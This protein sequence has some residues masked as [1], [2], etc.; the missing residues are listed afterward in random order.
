MCQQAGSPAVPTTQNLTIQEPFRSV[1]ESM[2]ATEPQRGAD[3]MLHELDDTTRISP[4]EG[5]ALYSLVV[6]TRARATLE[7]GLA[8]GF[9]TAYLLAG[10]DRNGGGTHTAIDPYQDTDWHGVGLTTATSLV[11]QSG[12]PG[13]A[14]RFLAQRSERALVDLAR[15]DAHFEV[16]FIDGYHRFDD[17]LV[18]FT[19]AAPMCPIGGVIVLHDMWLG[20][21][22]AVASF[23]LHN[24]GDFQEISTGCDNLFAVRRVGPDER[25]WDHFVPFKST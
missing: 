4:Q 12:L 25:N 16:T 1:L 15:S 9:S 8:F 3:G 10:L 24:R 20:S 2:H 13:D 5:A 11:Q 7:V 22:A 23:L 17:V 21:I 18:D 19:L 14:F 6:S